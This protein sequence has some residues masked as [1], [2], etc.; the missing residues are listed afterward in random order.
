[1]YGLNE[2]TNHYQV[3]TRMDDNILRLRF[4]YAWEWFK[5]HAGQRVTMFSYFLIIAGILANAY[6]G[7]LDKGHPGIAAGLGALGAFTSVGFLLLDVRNHQLVDWAADVLGHL[8]ESDIFTSA[9]RKEEAGRQVQLGFFFRRQIENTKPEMRPWHRSLLAKFARHKVWIRGIEGAVA[10]CFVMA[11][12]LPICCHDGF[13]Q[14]A[15]VSA[16]STSRER[17]AV[18]KSSKPIGSVTAKPKIES[19]RPAAN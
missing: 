5:Y 10:V 13:R 19:L 17:T 6:V 7:L 14:Q 1:M 2:P 16:D 11:T 4:D 15:G 3:K 8:E 9:F 12:L 18:Q